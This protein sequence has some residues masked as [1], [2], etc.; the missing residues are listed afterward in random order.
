M[1]HRAIITVPENANNAI[2]FNGFIANDIA[3][4][5]LPLGYE[6]VDPTSYRFKHIDTGVYLTMRTVYNNNLG[7]SVGYNLTQWGSITVPYIVNDRYIYHKMNDTPDGF[8]IVQ[9]TWCTDEDLT[10]LAF[11]GYNQIDTIP[12]GVIL[13][14]DDKQVDTANGNVYQG[15]SSLLGTITPVIRNFA[16]LP[17]KMHIS[18]A[19]LVNSSSFILENVPRMKGFGSAEMQTYRFYDI[20]GQRY[21]AIPNNLLIKC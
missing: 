20:N 17:G 7:V 2:I 3:P 16:A 1:I 15:S 11:S 8:G 12:G 9:L 13:N 21:L 10:W 14:M 6:L 4:L 5:L 19:C 18:D